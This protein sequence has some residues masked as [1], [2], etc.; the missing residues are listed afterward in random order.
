MQNA[1]EE[2]SGADMRLGTNI[3]PGKLY[4]LL[5][6][7]QVAG[8]VTDWWERVDPS[9]VKRPRRRLYRLTGEAQ[10]KVRAIFL[11]FHL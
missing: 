8:W 5:R 9:V 10:L 3:G 1:R 11:E 6:R 2:R 7:L 4:P